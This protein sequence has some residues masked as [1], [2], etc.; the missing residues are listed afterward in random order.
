MPTPGA[1]PDQEPVQSPASLPGPAAATEGGVAGQQH[2]FLPTK[3]GGREG[4]D[5]N[6]EV[7][8]ENKIYVRMISA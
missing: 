4:M 7:E 8:E 1:P 3:E 2:A 6:Q 5:S